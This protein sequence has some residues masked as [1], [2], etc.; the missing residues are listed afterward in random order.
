MELLTELRITLEPVFIVGL[1][2]IDAAVLMYEKR[3]GA[4]DFIV[5]FKR[6]DLVVFG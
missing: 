1:E 2:I 3:Y 5:V 6:R 4:L